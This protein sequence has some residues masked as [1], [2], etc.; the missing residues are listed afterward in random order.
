[1]THE[2][3]NLMKYWPSSLALHGSTR[4]YGWSTINHLALALHGGLCLFPLR[5][6]LLSKV[7]SKYCSSVTEKLNHIDKMEKEM[8]GMAQTLSQSVEEI[9]SSA[10]KAQERLE[11]HFAGVCVCTSVCACVFCM[12]MCCLLHMDYMYTYSVSF[13]RGIF[14]SL[15]SPLELRKS[16]LASMERRE[17]VLLTLVDRQV[18]VIV[19][20]RLGISFPD[21]SFG[22]N[23]LCT[24]GVVALL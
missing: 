1:M 13:M 16:Y 4:G 10:R 2:S 7:A 20:Y 21:D 6:E 14:T 24:W 3:C 15:L 22:Q 23:W 18:S 11:R 8:D 5:Y 17:A 9:D 19:I 12:C